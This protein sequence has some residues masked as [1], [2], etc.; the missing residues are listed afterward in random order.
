MDSNVSVFLFM[1]FCM[2]LLAL[3]AT[4]LPIVL[5]VWLVRSSRKNAEKTRAENMELAEEY[6]KERLNIMQQQAND[7]RE[8]IAYRCS[9]CDTISHIKKGGACV[10]SS[11]GA[12]LE[13]EVNG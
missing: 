13:N 3:I 11:C 6:K 1:I 4:G 9:F 10:C 8:Y 7:E 12:P 2:I 5:V